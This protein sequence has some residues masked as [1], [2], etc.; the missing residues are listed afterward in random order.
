[1]QDSFARVIAFGAK[2]LSKENKAAI[3]ALAGGM[4]YKGAVAN[5]AALEAMTGQKVG[6]VYSTLDTGDE[7]VWGAVSGT[8]QWIKIGGSGAGVE[9]INS[10]SYVTLQDS[11]HTAVPALTAEQVSTIYSNL[12][13]GKIVYIKDMLGDNYNVVRQRASIDSKPS[14]YVTYLDR[15]ELAYELGDGSVS[16]IYKELAQALSA[17]EG[18]IINN[19][20][21]NFDPDVL[22]T[23]TYVDM[24]I[25]DTILY[26]EQEIAS[27]HAGRVA[28]DNLKQDKLIAGTN[29]TINSDGK[30]I[31]SE[32]D[33]VSVNGKDGTV[34]LNATD[35]KL[36]TTQT[37]VQDN[38]IRVDEELGRLEDDK[39]DK[40]TGK[41]L[42]SND[43]TTAE[44]TKLANLENYDDTALK[45]RVTAI[46]SKIPSQASESNQVADKEFVN[47]SIATNTANYISNEGQPFTSVAQ[48]EAYTGTVTNND[49]AFVTGTDAAGNTFY[50][51]YKAT[52]SGT[53]KSWAKEYRLNNS[54]F[55]AV[56]WAAIESGIT[57]T[58]VAQISE[59][60]SDIANLKTSVEGI[61]ESIDDIN[62]NKLDSVDYAD[63]V[64]VDNQTVG[65][66]GVNNNNVQKLYRADRASALTNSVA[67]RTSSGQLIAADPTSDNH[68]TTKKYVD[69]LGEEK[70]DAFETGNGLAFN[71][72][73][74]VLSLKEASQTEI[75]GLKANE[76]YGCYVSSGN[77]FSPVKTL[78]QYESG[79]DQMFIG[80]GTLKN[81]FTVDEN[82]LVWYGPHT[83]RIHNFYSPYDKR[84]GI[85]YSFNFRCT[86]NGQQGDYGGQDAISDRTADANTDISILPSWM[87]WQDG[88][89]NK[90]G[91]VIDKGTENQKIVWK[92][93]NP[94]VTENA[95]IKAQAGDLAVDFTFLISASELP[96][97]THSLSFCAL[98]NDITYEIGTRTAQYGGGCF[99]INVTNT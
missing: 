72:G 64:S 82:G 35:I 9:I 81:I 30:T 31:N 74:T 33:V 99:S 91:Y 36:T 38:F 16:I 13:S 85:K 19:N 20:I 47:S 46:E 79:T 10:A 63:R 65:I 67:I 22:P 95:G 53:T 37:T 50:D 61:S 68:L 24:S 43:Y 76:S 45:G 14:I 48:L 78:S 18:F 26:F 94:P 88:Y 86:I 32:S 56:Q 21:L 84:P 17:G 12:A 92:I 7:Y 60:A 2:K 6:W 97:G 23:V 42:S 29:I 77:L 69:S 55:T 4:K 41:G 62:E 80:K 5:Y 57:S 89:V 27:E 90:I 58:H 11:M 40:V 3:E 93:I 1:M 15:L 83:T 70:Q 87:G 39:V 52:V 73:K 75:G 98:V 34:V 51:R 66:Y 8:N 96:K 49:Y 44:K 28:G 54:S 59:N 71:D 25:S